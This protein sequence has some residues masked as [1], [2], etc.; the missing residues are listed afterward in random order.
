MDDIGEREYAIEYLAKLGFRGQWKMKSI[1]CPSGADDHR[2]FTETCYRLDIPTSE[3]PHS[4]NQISSYSRKFH[5][6]YCLYFCDICNKG[7]FE[8]H[9]QRHDPKTGNVWYLTIEW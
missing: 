8:D 3:Y 2:E 5:Q 9:V 1:S 4:F 7:Q 6:I